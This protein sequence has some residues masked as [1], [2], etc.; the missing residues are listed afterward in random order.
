MDRN[1]H[2]PIGRGHR[3]A[4]RAPPRLPDV[5]PH[6]RRDPLG[7]SGL[8]YSADAWTFLAPCSMAHRPMAPDTRIHHIAPAVPWHPPFPLTPLLS[9]YFKAGACSRHP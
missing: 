8:V 4:L 5:T 7:S 6:L 3:I 2:W 9:R 1:P